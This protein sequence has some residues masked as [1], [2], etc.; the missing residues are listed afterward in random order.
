MKKK[1]FLTAA[2]LCLCAGLAFTSCEKDDDDPETSPITSITA[3]VENGSSYDI[4]QVKGLFRYMESSYEVV[5]SSYTNGGFTLN[6]PGIVDA[7]NLEAVSDNFPLIT[8]ISDASAKC[9]ILWIEGYKSDAYVGDFVYGK[10]TEVETMYLYCNTSVTVTG[11]LPYNH[12]DYHV[13]LK[14]GW[15]ILYQAT[16][17]STSDPGG[18]K[19][20]FDE[21]NNDLEASPVT[22]ITAT[23]ENGSSYD[24][25]QVKGFFGSYEVV[26]GNYTNGGFTL[27]LPET[28]DAQYLHPMS[29]E[30]YLAPLEGPGMRI[31]DANAQIAIL[32]IDG[33][34]SNV[35]VGNL[36]Y[37]REPE[38]SSE[39]EGEF[40]YSD[41]DVTLT[42]SFTN[43]GGY[44]II[45]IVSLKRG[46][47]IRYYV[48][49]PTETTYSTSDPG[50]LKWVFY[51]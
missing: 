19:W 5:S 45:M 41:R 9:A 25:D 43:R 27:N 4:D 1:Y 31:S 15:N 34:K 49:T 37:I 13:S 39:T 48:Q 33:Y 32:Q 3:T 44:E 10:G 7:K 16:T 6:L 29:D 14:K 12:N 8:E 46:W 36:M 50:G 22:F 47:N 28:V 26:S 38:L 24:I 40:V 18:L 35:R 42:G 11:S 30:E 51:E 21:G 23:V 2:C 17:L 20:S